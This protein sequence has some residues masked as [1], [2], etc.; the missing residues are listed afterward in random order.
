MEA[1]STDTFQ[2]TWTIRYTGSILRTHFLVPSAVAKVPLPLAGLVFYIKGDSIPGINTSGTADILG[3]YQS[4][5]LGK[6]TEGVGQVILEG[7]CLQVYDDG[8]MCLRKVW[9]RVLQRTVLEIQP[10]NGALLIQAAA[11]VQH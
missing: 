10:Y 11:G 2:E 6:A 3:Q 5:E 1:I 7:V 9:T 4:L 8:S